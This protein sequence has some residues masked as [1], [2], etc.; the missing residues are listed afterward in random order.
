MDE[1]YLAIR[2][3]PRFIEGVEAALDLWDELSAMP[4]HPQRAAA[5]ADAMADLVS[6]PLTWNEADQVMI[7]FEGFASVMVRALARC[8]ER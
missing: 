7:R 5:L 2:H 4:D 1:P 8:D 6:V 3:D